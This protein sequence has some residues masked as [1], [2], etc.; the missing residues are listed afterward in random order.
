MSALQGKRILVTRPRRQAAE[1]ISRLVELGTQ[2]VAFPVIEVAPIED[3]TYLDAAIAALDRFTWVIFTSANGVEAFWQR[4]TACGKDAAAFHGIKVAAIGPVT[5]E[6]LR[7]RGVEPGFVPPEYVA[8]AIAE[9]LG[10]VLGQRILLPRADIARKALAVELAKRG[11]LP[12]EIT[13]YRTQAA[14]P[15]PQTL[16]E[17]RRGVDVLTFTSSSTV[18]SFMQVIEQEGIPLPPS[19]VIACIGPITAE[20][21]RQLGMRVDL[22]AAE[23]TTAG[24]VEALIAYFN[25]L[26]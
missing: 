1:L 18:R 7:Q 24:L 4:L 21:A 8:E 25:K 10:D 11:A 5:A 14:R 23:Y 22:V 13:V 20:T 17:L 6:A 16:D 12:T 3:T 2:P 26:P 9:G 15:D 19:A